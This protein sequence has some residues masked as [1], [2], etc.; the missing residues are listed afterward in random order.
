M[1]TTTRIRHFLLL[2]AISLLAAAGCGGSGGGNASSGNALSAGTT[3]GGTAAT[4]GGSALLNAMSLSAVSVMP[5]T[6]LTITGGGFRAGGLVSVRFMPD[7][8]TDP[9]TI[10]AL[11]VTA[12]AVTVSVPVFFDSSSGLST[13]KTAKVEVIQFANGTVGVS[14]ALSGL[15]I[16]ALPP[17]PT[18]TSVGALT[19]MYLAGAHAIAIAT[20]AGLA[21]DSRYA[22]SS[23]AL[24]V[25]DADLS[26]LAGAVNALLQGSSTSLP[27]TLSNG[28]QLII[29]ATVLSVADQLIQATLAGYAAQVNSDSTLPGVVRAKLIQ[30]SRG[31]SPGAPDG[32]CP[33]SSYPVDDANLTNFCTF[34]AAMSNLSDP[35]SQTAQA[36]AAMGKISL[37]LGSPGVADSLQELIAAVQATVAGTESKAG[38][39]GVA[40]AMV[41]GAAFSITSSNLLAG[42]AP[43]TSEMYQQSGQSGLEQALLQATGY[44]VPIGLFLDVNAAVKAIQTAG[45][46]FLDDD[47]A[48]QLQG[49]WMV[50]MPRDEL[51]VVTDQYGS[52]TFLNVPNTKQWNFDSTTLVVDT[53]AAADAA[54]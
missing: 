30:V 18:M 20:Q 15:S 47:A 21:L 46:G 4:S 32:A 16:A 53:Y 45:F 50:P 12:S 13:A 8:G 29:N 9:V 28:D 7:D 33:G 6:E 14:Q 25:L 43:G 22:A 36:G 26:S 23:Q 27:V 3:S 41:T 17:V 54:P 39:V 24:G 51:A 37:D 19:A 5:M 44:P 35:S 2:C 49:G 10:P 48:G 31:A 1:N 42:D 38:A 34:Y 52:T 40:L 11:T